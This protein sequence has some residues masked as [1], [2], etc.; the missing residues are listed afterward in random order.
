[1]KTENTIKNRAKFFSLYYGQN[2]LYVGG[3]GLEPIGTKGWNINHPDFYLMLKPLTKLT[4]DDAINVSKI[5][6]SDVESRI[7]GNYLSIRIATR[8]VSETRNS[9]GIV[10]YLRS[11]GYA[12][13]YLDLSV[14]DLIEYGWIKLK[15]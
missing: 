15:D 14:E 11:K 7:L 12:I 6:G 1:M 4:D 2:V 3:V 10:D 13:P 8:E 5:W 9:V